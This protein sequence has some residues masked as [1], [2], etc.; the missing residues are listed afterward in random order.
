MAP[1]FLAE[2]RAIWT[3]VL[4]LAEVD[5]E[6]HF[7]S[8]GGDSLAAI[9]MVAKLTAAGVPA[10]LAELYENPRAGGYAAALETVTPEASLNDIGDLVSE[11]QLERLLQEQRVRSFGG[12][13]PRF[14][15]TRILP[16]RI[17]PAVLRTAVRATVEAHPLL[18]ACFVKSGGVWRVRHLPSSDVP[19]I[20]RMVAD[21]DAAIAAEAGTDLDLWRPPLFRVICFESPDG[22]GAVVLRLHHLLGDDLSMRLVAREIFDRCRGKSVPERGE[23]TFTH[24]LSTEQSH[25]TGPSGEQRLSYWRE[26]LGGS[27]VRGVLPGFPDR[28]ERPSYQAATA[29]CDAPLPLGPAA[30]ALGTTPTLVLAGALALHLRRSHGSAP[31]LQLCY[32][33]RDG[34][35]A[36]E[37][38]GPFF[39]ALPLAPAL[40]GAVDPGMVFEAVNRAWSG[41]LRHRIPSAALIRALQPDAYAQVPMAPF[42]LLN[43]LESRQ[44]G[45]EQTVPHDVAFPGLTF[46][47]GEKKLHLRYE[48]DWLPSV[49]AVDLLDGWSRMLTWAAG[50]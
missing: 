2:V 38:V 26:I 22:D 40:D 31:V 46:E 37:A 43:V 3:E 25:L 15:M 33:N 23:G 9:D 4:Q 44:I 36:H 14:V 32:A 24:L 17:D 6:T 13:L 35:G 28:P 12:M 10:S 11:A 8:A 50:G 19:V 34:T 18:R 21:L 20:Q 27:A 45:P 47:A 30:R 41:A 48:E 16:G 49:L 7:F 1:P 29:T 39:D 5:A 42:V